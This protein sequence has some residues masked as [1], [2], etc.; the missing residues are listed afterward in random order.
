MIDFKK[1]I[2]NLKE[3]GFNPL[4]NA[5]HISVP[6]AKNVLMRGITY[7]AGEEARWLPEYQV[8]A[9]WLTDN[10][11]R[12]L[13]CTG[14]CGRGKTMI[15]GKIIPLLLNHYC[16]KIVT[17]FDAQQMNAKID[18]IKRLHIIYIDDVGTEN[19]SVK[20]GE[21]RIAFAEIVDEAEKKGKMLIISTNLSTDEIQAK[22]DVRVLDRLRAITKLVV[23][24]GESMRK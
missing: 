5:V 9:D 16:R 2:E 15:C 23:F 10:N 14:N 20:F 1:T 24:D 7:F 6:D 3:V 12:G 22:Y 13:L 18:E 21:K 19:V 17:C 11:G 4:P 8:I